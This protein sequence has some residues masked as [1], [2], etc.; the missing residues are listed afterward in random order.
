[1][2]SDH[3]IFKTQ[4]MR[5]SELFNEILKKFFFAQGSLKYSVNG[6]HEPMTWAM[7]ADETGEFLFGGKRIRPCLGVIGAHKLG[8][9]SEEIM[10]AALA[11]EL[12][13]NFTLVHDD[14]EDGDRTRRNRETVW[15]KF[16]DDIAINT[17]G[18][19][20][21]LAFRVLE[22]INDPLLKGAMLSE[23]AYVSEKTHIGQ[24]LDM[25]ARGLDTF[26]MSRYYRTVL[27]KTGFC[28]GYSLVCAGMIY[29]RRNKRYDGISDTKLM[30]A[31][32][33]FS[34]LSGVLFQIVDDIIDL[35]QGKGRG[36]SGSDIMEGKRSCLVGLAMSSKVLESRF[37]KELITILDTPRDQ[38]TSEMIKRAVD[39]FNMAEVESTSREIVK[40]L[41]K[42]IH[43]QIEGMPEELGA[44]LA[45]FTEYQC[46]RLI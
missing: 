15:V 37:K 25:T 1:M 38:T 26:S 39:I 20:L 43:G 10:P 4:L 33:R 34:L 30:K 14:L 19:M 28:L 36:F 11:I 45:E 42:K 3:K 35:S 7:G 5:E 44:F 6:L 21:S 41:K 46:H 13:H 23:L 29:E 12:F 27:H 24:A 32:R 2:T 17:G 8:I 9:S 40:R 22:R 18:Y 16:G 31:L